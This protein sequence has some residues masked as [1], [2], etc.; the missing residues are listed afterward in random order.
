MTMASME[1][2]LFSWR[3]HK[4]IYTITDCVQSYRGFSFFKHFTK[5]KQKCDIRQYI[6]DFSALL[7]LS[8]SITAKRHIN[9]FTRRTEVI[10]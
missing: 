7:F 8:A 5:Q 4:R 3:L 2:F 10:S 9:S 6:T 1:T